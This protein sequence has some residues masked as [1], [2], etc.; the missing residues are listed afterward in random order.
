MPKNSIDAFDYSTT[1]LTIQEAMVVDYKK[2]PS[3]NKLPRSIR[4]GTHRI[5]TA[6]AWNV[7]KEGRI[8]LEFLSC[9]R[10]VRQ[11]V[12]IKLDGGIWLSD[13]TCIPVLRTWIDPKFEDVVEYSYYAKD[14]EM[15][16]W[17]VYKMN[18][19]AG[20][21]IEEGM[22]RNAGFWIEIVSPSVRIYHCSHGLCFPPDF[23]SMVFKLSISPKKILVN[24]RNA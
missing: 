23:E 8:R 20:Q 6:D 2:Y 16:I 1:G 3:K 15:R 14:S 4:W 11:G 9:S 19:P 18:Y 7:L 12:D 10:H 21:V 22:T 5:Q 17:N 24:A 13:G